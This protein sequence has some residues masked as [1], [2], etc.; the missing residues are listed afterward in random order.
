[1]E[2]QQ[3]GSWAFIAGVVLAVVSGLVASVA[4]Q[5]GAYIG[6]VLVILGLVVGWMNITDKEISLFL[7]ATIALMAGAGSNINA[8]PVVGAYVSSVLTYIVGFVAPAALVV[9]LKAVYTLAKDE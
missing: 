4:V 2:N 1:M 9:A 5:Y 8:I 3:I 7:L 6:P